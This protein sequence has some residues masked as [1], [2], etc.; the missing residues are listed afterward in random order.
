MII[1]AVIALAFMSLLGAGLYAVYHAGWNAREVIALQEKASAEAQLK[2]LESNWRNKY[3]A[4]LRAA[5]GR[6]FQIRSDAH[7]AHAAADEL[8]A[9]LTTTARQFA[10]YTPAALFDAATALQDVLGQC[11]GTYT[12]LAEAADRHVNDLQKM[13]DGWPK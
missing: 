6:E 13:I 9:Q 8:R 11:T 2:A 7:D 5:A 12:E 4:S 10:N 1:K 3:D